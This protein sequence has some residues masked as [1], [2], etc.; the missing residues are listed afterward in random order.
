MRAGRDRGETESLSHHPL[1]FL[2]VA[3]LELTSSI[4]PPPAGVKFEPIGETTEE[5][6]LKLTITILT[7]TEGDVEVEEVR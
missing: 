3:G 2:P 7:L 4:S 1:P 6:T 5:Q